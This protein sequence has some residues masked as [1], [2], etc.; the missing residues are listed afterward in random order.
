M[1]FS[2]VLSITWALA[3]VPA[4]CIDGSCRRGNVNVDNKNTM[5]IED[6]TRNDLEQMFE[7]QASLFV[8][9]SER[10]HKRIDQLEDSEKQRISEIA[11]ALHDRVQTII[12]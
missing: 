3:M 10:T 9:E 11:G 8:K 5:A 12:D 1:H 2:Q 4:S 7:N 6:V